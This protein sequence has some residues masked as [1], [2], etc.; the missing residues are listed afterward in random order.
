MSGNPGL[1]RLFLLSSLKKKLRWLGRNEDIL[2]L[3]MYTFLQTGRSPV[4]A[5]R[6]LDCERLICFCFWSGTDIR[7]LR[8][9]ATCTSQTEQ[10]VFCWPTIRCLCDI[11]LYDRSGNFRKRLTNVLLKLINVLRRAR[12]D[13]SRDQMIDIINVR[14]LVEGFVT[15]RAS[16][17]RSLRSMNR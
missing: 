17:F 11:A 9:L 1:R 2:T 8:F 14:E 7:R 10:S 4:V 6:H 16:N 12:S 13:G 15:F 3:P 5:G